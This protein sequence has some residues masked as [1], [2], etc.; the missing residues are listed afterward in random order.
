MKRIA[1]IHGL[2]LFLLIGLILLVFIFQGHIPLWRSLV[3]RYCLWIG[4]LF[5][6]QLPSQ[7]TSLGRIGGFFNDFSPILFIVL[8]YESLG[9]LIQY[10]H[11]DIDPWLIRIDL[12]LFGVHPTVWIERWIAPWLT[13][14]LSFFYG[15]YYFLP[16]ILVLAVYLRNPKRDFDKAMFVLLFGY[17]ISFIGYILFP[18]IGP[19]YTLTAFQT[20]PLGGGFLTDFIRDTLNSMEHNKRDC[21]PSGHT[22]I[23]LIVLTLS[24]RYQRWLF[25]LLVPT[26]SGIILSTV[27]L[28]HHY[29]ID[30]CVGAALATACVIVA[31]RIYE[32]W[33]RCR[34]KKI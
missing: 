8:I 6:L 34:E 14:L 17:Y 4:L 30:L 18:A 1:P 2:T 13:D 5:A 23:A 31:P 20:V 21:M 3:F 27:Y 32:G 15:I 10:L 33:N 26:V 7:R 24:Y 12:F 29:V 25:Y 11:S 28:R 9:D 22:G 19:R 16:V